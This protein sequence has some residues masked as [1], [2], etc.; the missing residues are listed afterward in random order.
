MKS[1]LYDIKSNNEKLFYENKFPSGNH[2]RDM[3]ELDANFLLSGMF[4]AHLITTVSDQYLKEGIAKAIS[5]NWNLVNDFPI[6]QEI[7]NEREKLHIQNS[8]RVQT[9]V[10]VAPLSGSKS[11]KNRF[12]PSK[13][14]V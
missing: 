4:P 6:L 12:N 10:L 13:I 8:N 7:K 1:A 5:D 3:F 9:S 11:I 14:N 2:E